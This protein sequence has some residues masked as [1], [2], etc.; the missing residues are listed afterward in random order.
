M[1]E[2][3]PDRADFLVA[4]GRV[5]R[6]QTGAFG[7]TVPF[8]DLHARGLFKALEQ[9]DRQRGR[10]RERAAQGGHIR[11]HRALHQRR[12][13][14]GH[15]DHIGHFPS[16]DQFP[17]VVENPFAA[18]ALRR[19][20]HSMRAR[21]DHRH[22]DR[23]C[24]KDVEQRQRTDHGVRGLEQQPLAQPTVI[25]HAR[26]LVLRHFGHARGAAGMEI[27]RNMIGRAVL[28]RQPVRGLLAAF[29]VKGFDVCRMADRVLG[30]DQR[31]NQLF[32]AT[33]IAQEVHFQHGLDRRRVL[34]SLGH[35][36]RQVGLWEGANR[37][38]NLGLGLAQDGGNLF[39]LE[40]R[41]DR[42]DDARYR[43]AQKGH[44]SFQRVGHHI[45][46]NVIF[47]DPKA[48]EQVCRLGHIGVQRVPCQ[49]FG[50]RPRR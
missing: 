48:A 41:V 34:D 9:F 18:I 31:H 15:S 46:H 38:H 27:G 42:V 45:G 7:Q 17:E 43:P 24:G 33:Q 4:I 23:I 25:E 50:F 3:Q 2:G 20:K 1:R 36:L 40:Q 30:A 49:G 10:A 6:H 21:C 19:G 16:L 44:R 22:H 12:K 11:I 39:C 37:D 28:E 8:D 29:S 13:G 47:P 5:D 26:K 14:G 32:D 35:L